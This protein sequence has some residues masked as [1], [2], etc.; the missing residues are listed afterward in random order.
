VTAIF[1]ASG[2]AE[3]ALQTGL[4][5]GSAVA[6][7]LQLGDGLGSYDKYSGSAI[8][9]GQSVSNDVSGIVEVS[10]NFEGTGAITIA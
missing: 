7:D 9:T 1:D 2:T 4:T 10:F 5:G 6:L 3:G 8:I